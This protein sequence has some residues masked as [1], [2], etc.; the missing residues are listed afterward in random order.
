MNRP[1]NPQEVKILETIGLAFH[2]DRSG[3]WKMGKPAMKCPP[4]R[5]NTASRVKSWVVDRLAEKQFQSDFGFAY[6]IAWLIR[7]VWERG[8]E[9]A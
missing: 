2:R 7:R 5:S 9:S 6:L 4:D 8:F 1:R 3:F